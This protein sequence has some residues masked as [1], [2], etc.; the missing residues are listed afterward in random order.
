MNGKK[1]VRTAVSLNME[2]LQRLSRSLFMSH[3]W[4]CFFHRCAGRSHEAVL[5]RSPGDAFGHHYFFQRLIEMNG[6]QVDDGEQKTNTLEWLSPWR[7]GR[8]WKKS[9]C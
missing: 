6:G 5:W 4:K 8:T 1:R 2:L 9:E 7:D 3:R